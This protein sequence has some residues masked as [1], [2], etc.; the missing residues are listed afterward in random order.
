MKR[1]TVAELAAQ[2]E[3]AGENLVRAAERLRDALESREKDEAGYLRRR[4]AFGRAQAKHAIAKRAH[5][6]A[7]HE[8]EFRRVATKKARKAEQRMAETQHV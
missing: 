5:R 1:P 8:E 6:D 7:V 2:V 3:R 4:A